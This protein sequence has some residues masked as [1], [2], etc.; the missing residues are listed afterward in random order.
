ML[1]IANP[2]GRQLSEASIELVMPQGVEVVTTNY[3]LAYGK[4]RISW[5]NIG[6]RRAVKYTIPMQQ[7]HPITVKKEAAKHKKQFVY[8]QFRYPLFWLRTTFKAGEDAGSIRISMTYKDKNEPKQK[9]TPYKTLTLKVTDAVKAGTPSLTTSA[10][11]G[12]FTLACSDYEISK[13]KEIRKLAKELGYNAIFG[14]YPVKLDG[15]DIWIQRGLQNAFEHGNNPAKLP[16]EYKFV[17]AI[18]EYPRLMCPTAI[19][20]RSKWY[21]DNVSNREYKDGV[22]KNNYRGFFH[23]LEPYVGY[24]KDGCICNRCRNEFIKHSGLKKDEVEAGWPKTVEE[25]L[26]KEWMAFRNWQTKKVVLTITE[27]ISKA[28]SAVGTKARHIL[29]T[30]ND[31]IWGA[32]SMRLNCK[33]WGDQDYDLTTWQY[34]WVPKIYGKYPP[35]DRSMAWQVGRSV[36]LNLFLDKIW[37]ENR[38]TRYGCM[39]GYEQAGMGWFTPEQLQFLHETAVFT[40]NETIYNYPEWPIFDG[41]WA[42]AMARANSRIKLWEGDI[43]KSKLKCNH[44]REI[45]SPNPELNGPKPLAQDTDPQK[46]L[47]FGNECNG[48][49][50]VTLEYTKGKKRIFPVANLWEYGECFFKLKIKAGAGKYI[51]RQPEKDRIFTSPSG[52]QFWTSEELSAGA[53]LHVGAV[54]WEVFTLEPFTKKAEGQKILQG[55]INKVMLE[56]AGELTEAIKNNPVDSIRK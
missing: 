53:L 1:S 34:Y 25:K 30:S 36:G 50:L 44:T 31:S 5:D 52:K 33:N 27:D 32:E 8:S 20:E 41:R 15:L 3:I 11:L 54:R 26:L 12:R 23:N 37:G 14:G 18:K 35:K 7:I 17:S 28:A 40:A 47:E 55:T 38:K 19:Y 21:M 13:Q 9:R 10:V 29:A 51:L 4:T 43:L 24:L 22:I 56:R 16:E 2:K 46:T 6:S 45:M 48:R 49:Y 42:N 39:Y